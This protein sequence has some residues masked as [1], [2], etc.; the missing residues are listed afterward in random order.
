MGTLDAD[1][2]ALTTGMHA[3]AA[4]YDAFVH[5]VVSAA[6]GA[7][8]SAAVSAGVSPP[9]ASSTGSV[10]LMSN[11]VALSLYAVAFSLRELTAAT[12]DVVRCT[13]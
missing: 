9:L 4:D 12:L 6:V 1:V 13:R 7:A 3:F 10:H 8:S 5:A 11:E 2:G